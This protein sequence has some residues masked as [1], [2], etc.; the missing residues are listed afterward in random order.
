MRWENSMLRDYVVIDLEMTGL[1]VKQDRI[2]E[3][4]AVRVRNGRAAETYGARHTAS[5]GDH[6]ADEYY[7]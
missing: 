6:G 3:T 2:L 1:K 5:G 7:G 4:G